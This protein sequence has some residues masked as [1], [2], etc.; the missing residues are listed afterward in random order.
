MYIYIY[1]HTYIDAYPY[2]YTH[3]HIH[4]YTRRYKDPASKRD[5][6]V[7]QGEDIIDLKVEN[8]GGRK[9]AVTLRGGFI[10]KDVPLEYLHDP[11]GKHWEYRYACICVC[12]CV[13]VRVCACVC[14]CVCVCVCGFIIKDVPLEYVHDPA[15]KSWEYRY[16]FY[17]C[18]C[19]CVCVIEIESRFPHVHDIKYL[20]G[21]D[22]NRQKHDE[23]I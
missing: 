15:E 9:A 10:I 6:W 18:M 7:A 19:V 22:G 4:T 5:V 2:K 23:N 13:C 3:T 17:M 11:E 12:V 20:H 8:K 16:A 1:I 21:H 14:V